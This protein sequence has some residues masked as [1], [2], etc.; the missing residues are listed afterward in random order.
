[1][2]DQPRIRDTG[3][4][5]WTVYRDLVFHGVNEGDVLKKY[6]NIFVERIK[7]VGDHE[8]T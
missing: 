4:R 1:M 8:K 5:V 3:L 7:N 2:D 6:D